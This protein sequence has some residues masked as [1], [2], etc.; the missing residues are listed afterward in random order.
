MPPASQP[1]NQNKSY[2]R[3]ITKIK[4]EEVRPEKRQGQQRQRQE[5]RRR[6]RQVRRRQEKVTAGC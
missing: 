3:Q 6:G 5:N 2:G 1:Q 4:S